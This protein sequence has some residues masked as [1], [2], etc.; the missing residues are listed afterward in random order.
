MGF[1]YY[2]NEAY[3]V[4]IDD[5]PLAHLKI[6]LLSLLRAGKSVAFSFERATDA[7]SGRETLWINPTTDL[8]FRFNGN[9][10]PLT[11]KPWVKAMITAAQSPTGLRLIP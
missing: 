4:E 3:P 8:R 10:P 11:N 5:R 2:G 7:G 1:L 9:R 6:A